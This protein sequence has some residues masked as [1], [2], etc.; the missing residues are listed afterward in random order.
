MKPV[1][2]RGH[3]SSSSLSVISLE[4]SRGLLSKVA[5]LSL[6]WML[7]YWCRWCAGPVLCPYLTSDPS[8]WLSG[9]MTSQVRYSYH[10]LIGK[11]IT[12]EPTHS[13]CSDKH[14]K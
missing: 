4:I 7:L 14:V 6:E 1:H 10:H 12:V 5:V 9:P 13:E 11:Q 2:Y 8:Q 3:T